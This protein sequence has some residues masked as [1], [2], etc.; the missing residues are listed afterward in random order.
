MGYNTQKDIQLSV[1]EK[2]VDFYLTVGA[3][4]HVKRWWIRTKMFPFCP[5]ELFII[6]PQPC[7][8]VSL[9][10]L[11][12]WLGLSLRSE[13]QLCG[14]QLMGI[15]FG[16]KINKGS[17]GSFSGTT[18]ELAHY[19][20]MTCWQWYPC[21]P[22]SW[23]LQDSHLAQECWVAH[24]DS[25]CD[26]YLQNYIK[27]EAFTLKLT[28]IKMKKMSFQKIAINMKRKYG[29]ATCSSILS[30]SDNMKWVCDAAGK[31]LLSLSLLLLNSVLSLI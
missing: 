21:L 27:D 15:S 2:M 14:P 28:L 3:Q 8:P 5:S 25:L 29:W 31:Y 16:P 26:F 17:I 19:F 7:G 18:T 30:W 12:P 22:V 10:G 23:M 6:M 20:L 4:N 24:L 13:P 9:V 1:T 11:N